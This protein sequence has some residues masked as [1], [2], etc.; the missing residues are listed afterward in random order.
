MELRLRDALTGAVTI[1][2]TSAPLL[3]S[4]ASVIARSPHGPPVSALQSF[5]VLAAI[6][7]FLDAPDIYRLSCVDKLIFSA[8]V[9]DARLWRD[10]SSFG[11]GFECRA[12]VGRALT[13]A[14]L[15]NA[16]KA[17]HPDASFLAPVPESAIAVVEAR[18]GTPLPPLLRSF[19]A[20][21]NGQDIS[22][23]QRESVLG[24]RMLP[25]ESIER[26]VSAESDGLVIIGDEVG[27][28]PD[29]RRRIVANMYTDEVFLL[30][31]RFRNIASFW[32]HVLS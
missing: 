28:L 19:Y 20:I 3:L 7:P 29:A 5:L 21:C 1:L 14:A 10:P 4:P 24:F 2:S 23:S 15:L 17:H 22:C 16:F 32:R 27:P 12:R 30:R 8:L 11:N 6:T 25:I 31:Q 18:L 13:L 9:S 26:V